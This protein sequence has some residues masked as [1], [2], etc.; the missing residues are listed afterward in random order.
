VVHARIM[1]DGKYTKVYI[2]GVRVGNG[3]NADLGRSK[4]VQFWVPAYNETSENV[5][6]IGPV[7]TIP[8]SSSRSR[9]TPTTSGSP[10]RTRH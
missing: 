7:R 4:K 10:S 5:T 2:N 1:A 3:P 9:D 6:M 8:S